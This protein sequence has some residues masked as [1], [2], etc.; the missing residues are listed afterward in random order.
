MSANPNLTPGKTHEF[1]LMINGRLTP[2]ASSLDVI[3]PATGQLLTTCARAD[4][5]QLDEAVAAAKTAFASWSATPLEQRRQALLK[6][7]DALTARIPEFARL[8]TEEQGKPLAH[9]MGELGGS[10]AMIRAF[11][12]MDLPVKILR[13]TESERIVHSP[14]D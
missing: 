12:A 5:A 14:H 3:N 4:K 8:L 1:R 13:E 6:I 7:A 2:G 11:A 9:A 10:V